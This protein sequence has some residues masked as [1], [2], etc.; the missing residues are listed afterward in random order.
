MSDWIHALPLGWMAVL[1]FGITFLTAAVI[2]RLVQSLAVGDRL[3]VFKGVSPGLLPPLGIIFGL[4][5]AF[6]ASQVWGDLDRARIAVN[7]EASTPTAP[8]L[9]PPEPRSPRRGPSADHPWYH[10]VPEYERQLELAAAR[11]K[12]LAVQP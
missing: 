8:P 5:V 2:H 11:R 6:L 3:R 1:I 7:R 9:L 10:R 12:W 4:L